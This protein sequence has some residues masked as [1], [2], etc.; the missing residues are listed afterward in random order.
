MAPVLIPFALHISSPG[1]T[2][3]RKTRR[4]APFSASN[5]Q[6]S[7]LIVWA[8]PF[9]TPS[10]K[11]K[12]I[13]KGGN[14][15]YSLDVDH[16]LT[17]VSYGPPIHQAESKRRESFKPQTFPISVLVSEGGDGHESD[18]DPAGLNAVLS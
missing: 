15:L 16:L 8:L 14:T 7:T 6:G 5:W 2:K 4:W 17:P 12:S 10:L 18:D 9:A 3:T 11:F 1:A 13:A